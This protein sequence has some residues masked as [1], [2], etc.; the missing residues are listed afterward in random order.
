MNAKPTS[1]LRPTGLV[2]KQES[3]ESFELLTNSRELT[4]AALAAKLEEKA[5]I[6][7]RARS[8]SVVRRSGDTSSPQDIIVQLE[9]SELEELAGFVA[10]ELRA[11]HFVECSDGSVWTPQVSE[12][13]RLDAQSQEEIR[14]FSKVYDQC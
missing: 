10:D 12:I 11:F 4:N 5:G 1:V 2:W 6:A 8:Q 9:R 14:W 13:E 7:R 3:R